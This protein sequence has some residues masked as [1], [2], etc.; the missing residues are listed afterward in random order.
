[1]NDLFS[2]RKNKRIVNFVV[3]DY[4]I[5]AIIN[6]GDELS[7]T[8]EPIEE[9]LPEGVVKNGK[10][11]N[12]AAF[13]GVVEEIVRVHGLKGMATRFYVPNALIIKL[14][15]DI[16]KDVINE[17]VKQYITMEIGH[18]I[19]LPFKNP[20]FDVYHIQD[21]EETKKVTLFAAPEEEIMQYTEL[22]IEAKLKPI[23]VDVQALGCYRYF[24][25]QLTVQDREKVFLL[26][27]INLTSVN[28]SIFH[29][30]YIEF[31]R[32]QPLNVAG[33][34]WELDHLK[35]P[36][37]IYHGDGTYLE[38]EIQDQINE[39]DRIMNFYQFSLHQGLQT[40]SDIVL[41]GDMPNLNTI[42]RA[43]EGRFS[44][45]IHALS[46]S[47]NDTLDEKLSTD[48][49]PALGLALKGGNK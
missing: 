44:L 20:H 24:Y 43:L 35:H 39:L 10:I 13:L 3:E 15:I 34:D 33:S 18:T 11:T 12:E 41:L 37:W 2:F 9:V 1:M 49:I 32:Y 23:A 36:R 16:P 38:G 21:M 25:N 8:E 22:F 27:E 48:F 31:L 6:N 29:Q 30:H 45:P 17:E 46:P 47:Q 14:D 7:I 42:H 26:F 5:R 19:H 40:V 4:V 28:I